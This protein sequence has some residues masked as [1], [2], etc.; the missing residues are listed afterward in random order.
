MKYLEL[1]IYIEVKCD[2]YCSMQVLEVSSGLFYPKPTILT[3]CWPGIT[4]YNSGAV[5]D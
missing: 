5:T 2:Y 4:A 1:D 3:R